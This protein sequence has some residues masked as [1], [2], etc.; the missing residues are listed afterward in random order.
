PGKRHDIDM[1]AEG[2]TVS[3]AP[4]LPLNM[5]D[6]LRA[7]DADTELKAS[8]GEEFSA[9]FLKLKMQEWNSYCSHFSDWEKANTLDI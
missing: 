2:H 7:Y 1:Y 6:A 8:M 5:L 3:G 4:L 9:A